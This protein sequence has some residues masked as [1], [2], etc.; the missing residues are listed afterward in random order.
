MRKYL[1][2]LGCAAV[3]MSAGTTAAFAGE[4]TGN[5]KPLWTSTS[6][7]PNTGEVSHTLH[8]QSACAFSGQEDL[9]YVDDVAAAVR[10]FFA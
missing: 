6:V 4:I 8:G 10:R 7:D 1:V 3:L 9:Q 2:A 5:G